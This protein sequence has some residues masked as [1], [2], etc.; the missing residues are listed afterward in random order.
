MMVRGSR[1][2]RRARSRHQ[3]IATMVFPTSKVQSIAAIT[4]P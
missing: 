3:G 1:T 2:T 4:V